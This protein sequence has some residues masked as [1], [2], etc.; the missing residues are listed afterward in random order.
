MA[1][2]VPAEKGQLH[3][4]VLSAP[5]FLIIVTAYKPLNRLNTLLNTLKGYET[6]PGSQSVFVYVDY[7]SR[8]DLETLQGVL[9]PNF[10]NLQ[11]TYVVAPPVYEGYSLTWAH[12]PFLHDLAE[13]Q[14]YDVYIYA[15][16]D[17]LFTKENYEYWA[18]YKPVLAPLGLEPGFCRYE[19]RGEQKIPFDNYRRWCLNAPTR[20]VWGS[21]PYQ[22]ESFLYLSDDSVVGFASLGNP[23]GGLMVLDHAD[24]QI[25]VNS[26]SCDP[27]KSY[28]LTQHRNW[29]IADRSS[30]GLA[31]ENLSFGR[32]HR[33]VVPLTVENSRL[34]VH[35]DGLVKHQDHKYS[36]ELA[37]NEK[38]LI[39]VDDM[40]VLV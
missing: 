10:Q 15:E 32:E 36:D 7:G 16:D 4:G 8:D 1:Y 2:D 39:T 31:F 24:L 40:F 18:K 19:T 12:K 23:Y 6:L 5:R 13:R 37:K 9:D 38:Q 35:P 25:Y 11:I 26:D 29:P 28:A 14:E 22:V 20:D 27:N 30:M 17:M 33:R 34:T 21:R 3:D